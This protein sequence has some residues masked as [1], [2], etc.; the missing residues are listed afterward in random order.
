M[1]THHMI[2]HHMIAHPIITHPM[3]I[4]RN[5]MCNCLRVQLGAARPIKPT[6]RK[7]R[8]ES[9]ESLAETQI[10]SNDREWVRS[11]EL[12]PAEA[13]GGAEWGGQAEVNTDLGV[14]TVEVER[15]SD[16]YGRDKDLKPFVTICVGATVR[17]SCVC[18]V[19]LRG[20]MQ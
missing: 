6:T 2:A 19:L 1:I 4:H 8:T 16:L 7:Q 12:S 10:N 15:V 14:L 3:I 11:L 20:C 18:G 5:G 9:K 17:Y 13:G